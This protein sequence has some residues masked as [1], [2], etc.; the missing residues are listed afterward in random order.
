MYLKMNTA[1]DKK[2]QRESGAYTCRGKTIIPHKKQ[3]HADIG[4]SYIYSYI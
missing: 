2:R 3:Y 1:K 4:L